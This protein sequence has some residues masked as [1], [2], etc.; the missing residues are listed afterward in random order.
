MNKN[1]AALR[2]AGLTGYT[3]ERAVAELLYANELCKLNEAFRPQFD[4]ACD[5]LYRSWMTEGAVTKTAP[6]VIQLL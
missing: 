2:D 3:A 1:L 5:A 4:K 6:S